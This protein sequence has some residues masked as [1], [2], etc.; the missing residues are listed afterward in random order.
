MAGPLW[1]ELP[2]GWIPTQ[3]KR[4]GVVTLGKML[5]SSN[6]GDDVLA[7]YL[8]AASV[9]PDGVLALDDVKQMWFSP[10]ELDALAVRA[11]DVVVVEGGQGGFGRAAYVSSDLDGWGLQNSINRIRP[12][13]ESDGRFLAYYLLALRASGFIHAYCNVVSMPHL[14]AEKLAA[15]PIAVPALV[16]QRAIADYLDRETA[17]I[18][19]LIVEQRRLVD[20]LRERRMAVLELA[21]SDLEWDTPLRAVTSLIQTGPFGSQ[22]KSDEYETGGVPVIN[23]SHLSGGVIRPDPRVAVSIDKASELARHSLEAG[24]LVVAR[25]GKLGTCAVVGSEEVGFLCGT[26]SA[27]VRPKHERLNSQFLHLV[28]SSRR[29][30]DALAL[31]SVGSTMDNLNADIVAA[32]RVPIPALETQRRIISRL[33]ADT[34]KVDELIAETERFVELACERRAAIIAAAVTGKIDVREAS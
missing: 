24:D 18:D 29:N 4:T 15:V 28:F 25:R 13:D 12:S 17:Q 1:D 8:R 10:N 33:V 3:V 34:S 22:L 27:L 30:K 16:V 6:S 14:T 7:P 21:V 9:Q 23:P 11:G 26:G 20:R 2:D 32:L 5:Q 19:T 31:A